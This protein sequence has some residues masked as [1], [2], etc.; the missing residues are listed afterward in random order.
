MCGSLELAI[1]DGYQSVS[2]LPANRNDPLRSLIDLHT[3]HSLV[4]D[5]DS[6]QFKDVVGGVRC[7]AMVIIL[8]EDRIDTPFYSYIYS[9]TRLN[10]TDKD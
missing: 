5:W 9:V 2:A 6:I 3:H 10:N 4:L 7:A 1:I 8:S